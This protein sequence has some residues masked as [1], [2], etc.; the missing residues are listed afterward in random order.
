MTALIPLRACIDRIIEILQVP[1][2]TVQRLNLMRIVESGSDDQCA[3]ICGSLRCWHRVESACEKLRT[4]L[5]RMQLREAQRC[6]LLI[7]RATINTYAKRNRDASLVGWRARMLV[8]SLSLPLL[9]CGI[10]EPLL[11]VRRPLCA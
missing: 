8:Y 6:A 5:G 1:F 9:S 3:D 4:D 2:S 11:S 7:T 10:S